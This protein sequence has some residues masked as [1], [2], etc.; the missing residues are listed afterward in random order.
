MFSKR[1]DGVKVKGLDAVTKAAPFFMPT[2]L[3]AQNYMLHEF[4]CEPIDEFIARQRR[5]GNNYTYTHIMMASLVRL[6]YLRPKL[7]YFVNH[8]VI[9]EHKDITICMVVKKKLNDESEDVDLKF[10]F[11]GRESLPQIKEYVDKLIAENVS[12]DSVYGTTK[13]ADALGKLP[14][15]LFRLAMKIIRWMDRHNMLPKKLI[16]ASCFHSSCFLT[17]LKSIKIDAINHHLYDFGTCSLFIAM[18]KEKIAPVVEK[19]K[20]LKLGKVMNVGLTMDE[21]VADGFYFGKTLRIWKDMF[22]N[23]DCLLEPM[24]ED[25]SKKMTIKKR[26]TKK[27]KV[28]KMKVKK[29]KLTKEQIAEQKLHEKEEKLKIREEKREEKERQKEESKEE[30]DRLREEKKVLK[31]EKKNHKVAE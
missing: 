17:N 26:K 22:E 1:S 24:P 28:K 3:G 29:Q 5:L 21:R 14:N 7:N 16:D 18:G 19:N 11:T 25:G 15:W 20:E 12:E 30:K 4:R 13:D 10:H 31:F 23:L 2:R 27:S 9:Y 6:L 8:N